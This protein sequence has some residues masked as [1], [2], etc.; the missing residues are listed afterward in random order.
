M[1][2]S[3]AEESGLGVENSPMRKRK[4]T[5]KSRRSVARKM[6]DPALP[7]RRLAR[8]ARGDRSNVHLSDFPGDRRD[9]ERDVAAARGRRSGGAHRRRGDQ[10]HQELPVPRTF[11]RT[12][13]ETRDERSASRPLNLLPLT[14][15]GLSVSSYNASGVPTPS[16]R[17]CVNT[18]IIT[19]C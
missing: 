13:R 19:L 14:F 6:E 12:E 18:A 8:D 1:Q 9:V 4:Q 10:Q 16:R 11:L 17:M 2:N 3:A 5:N 7:L 15:R